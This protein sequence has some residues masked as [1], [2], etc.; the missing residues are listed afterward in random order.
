MIGFGSI[1]AEEL[2]SWGEPKL[3]RLEVRYTGK[4]GASY[5]NVCEYEYVWQTKDSKVRRIGGVE[6]VKSEEGV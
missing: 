5:R 2:A 3:L 4:A 1:P 6:L